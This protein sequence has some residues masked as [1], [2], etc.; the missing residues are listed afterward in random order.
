VGRNRAR[1]PKPEWMKQV[2]ADMRLYL[3]WGRTIEHQTNILLALN[4]TGQ[5]VTPIYELREGK[6]T[7]PVMHQAEK[8]AITRDFAESNIEAGKAYRAT[9]EAI[10]REAAGGDPDKE[11]F[12]RRYWWTADV[13]ISIRAR[14]VTDALPFLAYRNEGAWV[15]N[16]NFYRWRDCI[17]ERLAELMGYKEG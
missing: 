14:Y 13:Q 4:L 1:Q 15:P 11:T 10:A 7:G 17:Y 5:R 16:R 8:V 6:G 2:D 9:L 12:I 3:T